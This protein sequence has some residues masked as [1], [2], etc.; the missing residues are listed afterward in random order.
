MQVFY[1]H[2]A[3]FAIAFLQKTLEL[4]AMFLTNVLAVFDADFCKNNF[5]HVLSICMNTISLIDTNPEFL[6][7]GYN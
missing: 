3:V 5:R 6:F 1:L 2:S 7:C 4:G